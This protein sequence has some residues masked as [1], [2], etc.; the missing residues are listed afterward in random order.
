MIGLFCF[1][2]A[3]LTSPF[4]SKS[5]LEAENAVLRLQ[6]IVLRRVAP[7]RTCRVFRSFVE[8]V[9]SARLAIPN[10]TIEDADHPSR[11]HHFF[12]E[13]ISCVPSIVSAGAKI[14]LLF[15]P[16]SFLCAGK[17]IQLCC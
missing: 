3:I 4:R 13:Y 6:L 12:V 16:A 9:V 8:M 5:R 15:H 1:V 11:S 17:L 7:R 10:M 14:A 2:F